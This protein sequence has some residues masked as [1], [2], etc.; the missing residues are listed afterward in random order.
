MGAIA[1][2]PTLEDVA[3]AAGVSRAL[4]SIVI[5]DA[6]GASEQTRA[7]VLAIANELGYRPDARARLLARSSTR[8]LGVTYRIGALHHADLLG[9]IYD[10][11]EAAGYEVILS[12]MTRHHDERRALNTLL[13]YRCEAVLM[14][15]PDL[16]EPELN[17]LASSMPV[18][19]VGRRMIH[20]AG[21]MDTVRT[22]EDAGL[23]LAVEHLVNLGHTRIVHVDGGPGT[24]AS[25]RRRGYRSSMKNAGLRANTQVLDGGDT[26]D[27][28]RRAGVELLILDAWPTAVIAYNDESAWGVMRALTAQG[29]SVPDD[30]SVVGYDGSP[31]AHLAPRELTTVRQDVESIGRLSVERAIAR[32]EGSAPPEMDVVLRPALV[33]GETTGPPP[34]SLQPSTEPEGNGWPER[35]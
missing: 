19:I 7:R 2:K 16:P 34:S 11:A 26:G 13:G 9:P 17:R 3:Q 31:L 14:L 21:A 27:D 22:D 20:P 8:V 33:I 35:S 6:A 4:V 29:V 5:R 24:K 28:G 25:D 18:V 15:G 32:L 10:A 1:R 23:H 12:G 30:I